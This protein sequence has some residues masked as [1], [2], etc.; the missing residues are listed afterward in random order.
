MKV[1]G[2]SVLLTKTILGLTA[3]TLTDV[4]SL[5]YTFVS[6]S[7]KLV[8]DVQKDKMVKSITQTRGYGTTPESATIYTGYKPPLYTT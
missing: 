7:I 4:S 6:S 2:Y 5:T 1:L 8:W 3:V